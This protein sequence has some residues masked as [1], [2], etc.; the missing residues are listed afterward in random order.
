MPLLSSFVN[1][2]ATR[3]RIPAKPP[4]DSMAMSDLTDKTIMKPRER[5]FAIAKRIETD[6]QNI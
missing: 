6:L 5:H 4:K 2:D 3:I 1:I